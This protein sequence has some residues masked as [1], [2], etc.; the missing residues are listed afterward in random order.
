MIV[1]VIPCFRVAAHVLDVLARV[2]PEVGRIICVDDAC[3][4]GSG[5]LIESWCTDARVQVV[6]HAAN[7]GVGGATVT[8]FRAALQAG[9]GVVV[10]LDGDGQMDPALIPGL[11]API[12]AG[13]ADASKG[14]RFFSPESVRGMPAA[15]LLG[16]AVLSFITKFST[17]YWSVFDPTNGFVAVHADVLR[18][19]PLEKLAQRYFFESDL[20][21]RL[22]IVRAVVMDMPMR[23]RYG[24]ETS[25][26]RIRRVV[27]PFLAGHARNFCKRIVYGYF[28]RDFHVASLE[29]ILGVCAV[30]FGMISGVTSW[31]HF[32]RLG[33]ETPA[34]S[35]MLAALPLFVGVQLLLAFLNFDITAEPRRPVH[36]GPRPRL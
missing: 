13:V 33:R 23:A 18:Q 27:G 28:L 22:S 7:L 5:R 25:G 12:L 9:A 2:G 10:K 24:D 8:G 34:G 21:F 16:N 32:A 30:V 15:R 4:E 1:V 29:L 26:L 14:N 3:P 36:V 19:L 11:I 31:H 20:L 6:F 17:G 35:V